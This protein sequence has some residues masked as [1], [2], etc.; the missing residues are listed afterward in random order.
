MPK[1][2]PKMSILR[3]HLGL[4]S[5]PYPEWWPLQNIPVGPRP[6]IMDQRSISCHYLPILVCGPIQSSPYSIV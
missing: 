2:K 4:W 3:H 6:N 1:R 5:K